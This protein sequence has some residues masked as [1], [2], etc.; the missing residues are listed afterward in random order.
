MRSSKAIKLDYSVQLRAIVK[1]VI[2]SELDVPIVLAPMAGGPSTPQLASA[3]DDAGGLAFIASGYLTAEQTRSQIAKTRSHCVRRLG[4]NVFTPPIRPAE[5]ASYAAYAE[6]LT[7]WAEAKGLEVGEPRYSDDAFGE[8]IDLLAEDP[9]ACVSFTFG[10]PPRA[11][12]ERLQAAGSE[13]WITVTSPQEAAVAVAAG[14]DTL[15]VQGT[16]AGGHRGSFSD[17]EQVPVYGLLA[18]LQLIAAD[19]ELPLVASGGIATGAALAAALA[20]GAAAAQIGTAF[21]LCPEAGTSPAH[22]DALQA[23]RET[24]LTRA[25]TGR[26]ARGIRNALVD[27]HDAVAPIAYPEVHYLTAPLRAAARATGDIELINLWAG[28]A[29]W[30]ARNEPARDVVTRLM[31]EARAAMEAASRRVEGAPA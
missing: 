24:V 19:H 25:F 11:V 30:L 2:V 18:L 13:V 31:C 4:V 1:V 29:H 28:Q 8:K 21:M 10:C 14:A 7:A 22:R 16:E 20:V 3:V 17:H 12:V 6:R 23:R 9:V 15:I 26:L 5:P 27:E